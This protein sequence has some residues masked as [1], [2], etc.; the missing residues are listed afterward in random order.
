MIKKLKKLE[1]KK[2]EEIEEGKKSY[3]IKNREGQK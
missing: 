1:F 2:K 3:K